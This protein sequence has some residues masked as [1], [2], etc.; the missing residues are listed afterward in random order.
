M[1]E[2]SP[3]AFPRVLPLLRPGWGMA[4]AVLEG[5]ARGR[6][7]VDDPARPKRALIGTV[8]LWYLAGAPAD[9][10]FELEL[11]QVVERVV[12][13][14]DAIRAD[15]QELALTFHP[16]EWEPRL[17]GLMGE[18]D[19]LSDP[20]CYL[21][22]APEDLRPA[23]LPAGTTVVDVNAAFL[24]ADQD[25]PAATVREWIISHHLDQEE[26]LR[27]CAGTLLTRDGEPACWCVTDCHGDDGLAEVGIETAPRHRRQGLATAAVA[28]TCARLFESGARRI[29]WHC[30]T[31][32]EGSLRTA[33]RVG[34]KSVYDYPVRFRM[35]DPLRHELARGWCQLEIEDDPA[36]AL[37][38]LAPLLGSEP[39]VQ[40]LWCVVA[41]RAAVKLGRHE[42]ALELL[43]AGRDR[44][45]DGLAELEE[46]GDF[47]ALR[48]HPGWS[49]LVAARR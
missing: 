42:Q 24:E 14:G 49:Q 41:A 31:R 9:P 26:F 21:E 32:N 37:S 47:A 17:A 27:R 2:L 25:G 8:E 39:E 40:P 48:V 11:G 29:G 34:F 43:A 19:P 35:L 4:R 44:G 16:P 15:T 22:L 6:V 23:E 12:L 33:A 5:R 13:P 1:V 18:C 20:R 36:A 46:D 28:H 38:V 3:K 7:W 45:W 30:Y 10:A